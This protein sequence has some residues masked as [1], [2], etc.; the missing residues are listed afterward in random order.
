MKPATVN[1]WLRGIAIALV[2]LGAAFV[3]YGRLVKV[4][5]RLVALESRVKAIHQKL[6]SSQVANEEG[7]NAWQK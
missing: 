5:T 2:V 3:L 4:E 6:F 1:L 7:G